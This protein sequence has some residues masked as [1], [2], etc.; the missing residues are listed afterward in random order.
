MARPGQKAL[1]KPLVFKFSNGALRHAGMRSPWHWHH[2]TVAC[3]APGARGGMMI[4]GMNLNP[5]FRLKLESVRDSDG[6]FSESMIAKRLGVGDPSR[7]QSTNQMA[8]FKVASVT[9]CQGH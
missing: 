4:L 3:R 6:A 9:A 7:A 5:M 8:L 2:G 1:K